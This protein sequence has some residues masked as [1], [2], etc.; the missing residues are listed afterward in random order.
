MSPNTR[1]SVHNHGILLPTRN[2]IN[3]NSKVVLLIHTLI[4]I[5]TPIPE[6]E[7]LSGDLGIQNDIHRFQ[8]H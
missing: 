3:L 5:S 8:I 6:G 4:Q 7:N 2:K 1:K